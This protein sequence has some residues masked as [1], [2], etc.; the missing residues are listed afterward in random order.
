MADASEDVEG[1]GKA[2]EVLGIKE[3]EAVV[4][5]LHTY[6]LRERDVTFAKGF[7]GYLGDSSSLR[8]QYSRVMTG[9]KVFGVSKAALVNL[10][11]FIPP[12][13]E[14]RAIATIL[15]DLDTEIT[16]LEAKRDKLKA[17][18]QGMMQALLT[19]KVRLL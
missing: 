3:G 13:S 1:V 9:M 4:A 10:K 19:G 16:A 2:I 17:I 12:L 18:K 7:K 14:Q 8:A 11:I 6:L 15:T 5:G